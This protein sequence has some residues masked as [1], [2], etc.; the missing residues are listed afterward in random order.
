MKTSLEEAAALIPKQGSLL[1]F[2]GAGISVESGIPSFR[3]PGGLWESYDP[4]FI[5]IGSF[6]SHPAFCWKE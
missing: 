1:I 2:T 4:S 5:E 6:Y 3:G